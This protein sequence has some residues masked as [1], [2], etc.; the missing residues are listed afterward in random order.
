MLLHRPASCPDSA[1]ADE[2]RAKPLYVTVTTVGQF[3]LVFN[4]VCL[5][6][7]N[8]IGLTQ[9]R[10]LLAVPQLLTFGITF[11]LW[12]C[13]LPVAFLNAIFV[14]LADRRRRPAPQPRTAIRISAL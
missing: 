12:L 2:L 8:F 3:I 5:H 4:V 10:F 9:V 11:V 1:A 7:A 6:S 14:D 13:Y